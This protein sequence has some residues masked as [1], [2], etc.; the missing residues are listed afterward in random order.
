MK[1]NFSVFKRDGRKVL[2]DK[3]RI[4][5][6]IIKAMTACN[7]THIDIAMK[8]ANDITNNITNNIS[9]DKIEILVVKNLYLNDL[10]NV[11]NEY[12]EYKTMRKFIRSQKNN[13]KINNKFLT[14]EFLNKYKH[15]PSPFKTELGKF[16]Y[17]RTYSRP[18]ISENRR[19]EWWETCA[20]VV[21]FNLN[22][23]I[24]ALIKQGIEIT[25]D[26]KKKFILEAEEIYDLMFNLK[27]FPSG[28]TLWIGGTKSSKLFP[29]SNFNCSFL[30]MNHLSK[31]SELFFV[32]MLGTGVGLSV[33]RQYINQLPKIN[34]FIEIIHKD[35]EPIEKKMRKEYTEFKQIRGNAIEI[36]IGDSKFGWSKAIDLYFDIIS[37]KQYRD[38]N[39]IFINYN[40]VRPKGERL[41]T[42]GGYASG[43]TN[44]KKM[45][46]KISNI[47]FKKNILNNK[48]WQ[49]LNPLDCLDIATIIAENVV[50]GGVRRSA[51]IIFC[52]PDEKDILNAKS[53]LYFQNENGKWLENKE[54]LNRSLANNTVVYSNKP[55]REILHDHFQKI[56]FSGEPSFANLIEMKNRRNDAQGGNP[57]FEILLRDRGI[58]NL[59]EVNL[60]GFV[61]NDGSYEKKRILKAQYYSARI[62]YRMASIELELNEWDLVNKEDRLLGC[63]LTGVMDFINYTQI[64]R[65]ELKQLLKD[66]RKT[67]RKAADD[68]ANSFYMNK[69]KLITTIKPSGTISQ[70]PTVSSG[71][72]FSHSDYYIRRVRVSSNDPIAAAMS[73][74][75]FKW[76]PEVGETEKNHQIKVFEFPVSSPAKKNK[77]NVSA[78]E[79]LE[80][81]K[82]FMKYYVDHNVSNTIHVRPYEWDEVEE[83]VHKNWNYVVGITFLSLDDS[84]YQ[85]LPYESITKEV[86]DKMSKQQPIFDPKILN[87]FETFEEE[88]EIL[89][90]DCE[91][92][93]CPVR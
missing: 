1:N 44:I 9:V 83:W 51:E 79:Q 26:I 40:N 54:I 60:M 2:F 55:S 33:E 37:S 84:F 14:L 41:K 25:E 24:K 67:A 69:S 47:F 20:R 64:D 16:V 11:A 46:Q 3:S 8:I 62:G 45:F 88:Y 59:T 92:G 43:H 32:L 12:S 34:T 23:G 82:F 53:N 4:T 74:C 10:D 21:E 19:E 35:Y 66:L 13:I 80:W 86:Y 87:Q 36:E 42:F 65:E 77:Y 76:K 78:I 85:L 93:K 56:K 50:S 72:H 7:I 89:D 81:Y 18:I 48:N 5:N 17:Y 52:D 68:I 30:T 22:L 73:Y 38:I 75:G 49:K 6:A 90:T 58:C 71:I 39:Y 29:I 61:N 91:N 57:C 27:L 15:N 70:L 63:S 31:F 28:R